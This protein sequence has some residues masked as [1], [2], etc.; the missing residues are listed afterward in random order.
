MT[1]DA[2]SPRIRGGVRR[3]LPLVV[4]LPLLALVITAM[5]WH[6][7]L[8]TALSPTRSSTA[9]VAVVADPDRAPTLS[10]DGSGVAWVTDSTDQDVQ[11]I[12]DGYSQIVAAGSAADLPT[13]KI[14]VADGTRPAAS[15]PRA[16]PR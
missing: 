9:V 13:T 6:S 16:P 10:G 3:S 4:G 7:V 12:A 2:R 15:G 5:Y 14:I 8:A 1:V 11:G